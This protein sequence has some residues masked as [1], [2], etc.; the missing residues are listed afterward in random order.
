MSTLSLFFLILF[1]VF[2]FGITAFNITLIQHS[3]VKDTW[4]GS[5]TI[6]MQALDDPIMMVSTWVYPPVEIH[7]FRP[8]QPSKNWKFN[9]TTDFK[10]QTLL[11][12]S[13][14]VITN[15]T[16]I[17]DSII[18]WLQ[19]PEGPAGNCSLIGFNSGIA[20]SVP[21]PS[22]P[23]G[24]AGKTWQTYLP[25][26]CMNVNSWTPF[27]TFDLSQSLTTAAGWVMDNDGNYY[28]FVLDAQT[29]ALKWMKEF[30]APNDQG[31]VSFGVVVSDSGNWILYDDGV[32]GL[33]DHFYYIYSAADGTLRDV[34]PSNE[35]CQVSI[36]YDGD[37]VFTTGGN[38]NLG[39]TVHQYNEQAGA[40]VEMG[41][42]IVIPP[43]DTDAYYFFQGTFAIDKVN[44][45]TLVAGIWASTTLDGNG[46]AAVFDIA[47]L[48][49]GP[50]AQYNFTGVEN[51]DIA[52]DGAVIKCTNTVCV[53][54]L[55]C[56]VVNGTKPTVIVLDVSGNPGDM[57]PP[58]FTYVTP[59][60]MNSVA[61][62]E[63]KDKVTNKDVYY[64]AAG[65]CDT[66]GVCV[67]P[68]ADAYIW[69]L[70]N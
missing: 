43:V 1:S 53:I 19:K 14:G 37:Y 51:N 8:N 58:I 29:G 2:S 54:G 39:I 5:V 25:V 47:Q 34:I 61:I 26:V 27:T 40:Y 50:I 68:G 7:A 67:A 41:E 44:N 33:S 13:T 3:H 21:N 18:Y 42:G 48:S 55:Q 66:Y 57:T 11:V 70:S 28:I 49:K 32:E 65:G 9:T 64:F 35:H 52:F 45:R 20:P 6:G 16:S 56:Q 4:Y 10:Y 59:G 38:G 46:V 22:L 23:I 12:S 30:P 31:F 62:V 63:G 36:S 17:V 69:E 15:S 60:S 24:S